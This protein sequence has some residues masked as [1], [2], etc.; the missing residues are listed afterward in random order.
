MNAHEDE[1]PDAFVVEQVVN[2]L[3]VVANGIRVADFNPR[4]L[5]MPRFVSVRFAGVRTA[6][7]CIDGQRRIWE[8]AFCGRCRVR[9]FQYPFSRRMFFV[10]IHRIGRRVD[11]LHPA[12]SRASKHDVH[13]RGHHVHTFCGPPCPVPVPHIHHDNSGFGS[14]PYYFFLNNTPSVASDSPR[15]LPAN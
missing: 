13:P 5:A 10:K 12:F 15:F 14:L 4:V 1:V 11:N 3:S 2:F 6:I 9:K 8:F 7:G